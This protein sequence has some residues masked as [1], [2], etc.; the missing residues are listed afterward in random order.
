MAV[1]GDTSILGIFILSYFNWFQLFLLDIGDLDN[2]KT[3][4]EGFKKSDWREFGLKAGLSYNTLNEIENNKK[5]VKDRF[6]ECLACW[7][8]RED[9]VD[10]KGKP[11][12]KR[13]VEILK[14]LGDRA[15]AD[16]IRDR[17]GKLKFLII[18]LYY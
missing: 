5:E 17:K 1:G 15:L 3:E 13:L 9:K 18:S 12:W 4:L 2:V 14:E 16:K 11:S 7:L 8:R 10:E 6:E